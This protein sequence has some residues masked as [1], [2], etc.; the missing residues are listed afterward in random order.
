MI[1]N[2]TSLSTPAL[3]SALPQSPALNLNS[4]GTGG[5]G[6]GGFGSNA[7]SGLALTQLGLPATSPLANQQIGSL[8]S[9]MPG[10]NGIPVLPGVAQ[11]PSSPLPAFDY[12]GLNQLNNASPFYNMPYVR[13]VP[14]QGFYSLG[15]GQ[16]VSNTQFTAYIPSVV[17]GSITNMQQ[18]ASLPN[19]SGS[20]A[21]V[22]QLAGIPPSVIGSSALNSSGS[23]VPPLFGL[24]A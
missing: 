2:V 21:A 10:Y 12:S 13:Q 18:L 14:L 1:A 3:W 17:P 24:K 11:T 8:T 7:L 15:D 20:L 22:L 23:F 6:T 4:F 16:R 19:T 5:F 9:F